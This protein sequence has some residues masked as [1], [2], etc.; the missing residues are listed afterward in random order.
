MVFKAMRLLA[1]DADKKGSLGYILHKPVKIFIRWAVNKL[2]EKKMNNIIEYKKREGWV[3]PEIEQLYSDFMAVCARY[4]GRAWQTEDDYNRRF[5][6]NLFNCVC[7]MLDEDT[8]YLLMFLWLLAQIQSNIDKYRLPD[9]KKA[10]YWEWEQ[11]KSKVK[12]WINEDI[13]RLKEKD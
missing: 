8:Y 10:I 9:H 13:R 7:V 3:N 2:A 5:F 1:A 12:Q 11:H 4:E 6:H